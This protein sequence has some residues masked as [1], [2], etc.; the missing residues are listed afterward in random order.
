MSATGSP[1]RAPG[2]RS[3]AGSRAAAWTTPSAPPIETAW[4]D[5]DSARRGRA[6]PGLRH[7]SV[8]RAGVAV[9]LALAAL[10]AASARGDEASFDY[11]YIRAHESN[12]SGGHAALRFG[13][14]CLRLPTRR[15]LA[16]AASRGRAAL[17][18]PVPHA[19][20]PQ[21]R[22]V[23][24]RRRARDR[25]AA[26][27][28][29]R[30]PPAR[31]NRGSSRSATSCA[32][33]SRCSPRSPPVRALQL[34]VRGAGFFAARRRAGR[35]AA[36]ARRAARAHRR[37][38][39]QRL[40][41]A[42]PRRG[43]ARLARSVARHR[44]RPPR[45]RSTR[46][47]TR[48]RPSRCRAGSATRSPRARRPT[49]SKRRARSPP[50]C[51]R[52]KRSRPIR[53]SRST[54]RRASACA[55]RAR[56]SPTARSRWPRAAARIGAQRM[57]LAAA[58]LVAIDESLAADR[59]ILL[60]ALP[61]N[62]TALR[63]SKR[64]RALTPALLVE[65]RRDLA[66]ARERFVAATRFS[67]LEWSA[68]E[69]AV[70][71]VAELRAVEQR[72]GDVSRVAGPLLPEGRAT[73]AVEPR[74]AATPDAVSH[75]LAA[76][77]AAER[78]YDA[79]LAARYRY[80]LITRNCVSEL[81]RTIEAGLARDDGAPPRGR[82]RGRARL[83][84]RRIAAPPRRLRRSGGA[85]ELH[86]LRVVA[87]RA[88]ELGRRRAHPPAVGARSGGRARGHAARGAARVERRGR[89]RST[90]PPTAAPSSCSSP[91]EAG[92]CDRC[93]APSISAPRSRAPESACCELPLDRGR[94]LRAGL[95][96]ALFSLP[97]LFF[98][99]IRKGT[100]EYVPPELRPPP[101]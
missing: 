51:A 18:A 16:H 41:R 13:D 100:S 19:P 45:S 54:P 35:R 86:P 34:E 78:D 91:T 33:T 70:S 92:R 44:S 37:A 97:E 26:A 21:H 27:R 15:R 60:D 98:A 30:A 71:R 73:L 96:G 9:A 77:R 28:H 66:P 2:R 1:S 95:E 99:N 14:F 74:P 83:R 4:A 93:S 59:L 65:A 62:A 76:A 50:A 47:S 46:S 61:R 8:T 23:A 22:G 90:R 17:P 84:R 20:E 68:L 87:Q 38:L 67:E 69:E 56:R 72:R 53:R 63:V 58:R 3:G 39:R 7:G 64:R 32:P 52:A 88:R 75:A 48:S 80:D 85:R 101:G 94:G 6:R 10:L 24:H 5:G 11:L 81:F 79:A 89:R 49:C 25:R 12:A 57:L 29:L 40:A 31:R 43:R 36:G 55:P 82:S 42:A